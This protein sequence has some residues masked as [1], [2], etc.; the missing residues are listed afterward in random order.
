MKTAASDEVLHVHKG[1]LCHHSPVFRAM[2]DHDWMET[3]GSTIALKDEDHETF[4]RFIVWLY[5]GTVIDQDEDLSTI[6]VEELIDCYFLADRRDVPA[7]QNHIIDT[8]IQN[9]RATDTLFCRL[10]RRIW[11]NTPQQSLLRNLT[12]DSLVF[13]GDIVGVLEDENENDEY[14]KSFIVDVLIA[15]LKNLYIISWDEFYKRRCEYHIH[16]EQ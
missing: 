11:E 14:D 8:L 6:P 4:R 16:N 7:M 5:Y 2:L 13:R 3:H 9:M 10:Q 12:V 1:L 15:K